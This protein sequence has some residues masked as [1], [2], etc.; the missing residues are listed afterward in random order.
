MPTALSV[1]ARKWH[2]NMTC[3][4]SE[5]DTKMVMIVGSTVYN[6]IIFKYNV[7]GRSY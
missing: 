2:D 4:L 3:E 6:D 1:T 7:H 5:C